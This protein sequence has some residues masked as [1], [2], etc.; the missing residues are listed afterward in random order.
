MKITLTML[1]S[2]MIILFVINNF[3]ISFKTPYSYCLKIKVRRMKSH[4]RLII[5]LI[6]GLIFIGIGYY[7]AIKPNT[8][9]GSL[10]I[11]FLRFCQRLLV[12]ICSFVSLGSIV[13]EMLQKLDYYYY[14]PNHFSFIAGLKS[15]V[16][17]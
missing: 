2:L 5:F 3:K 11:I 16:K 13:L 4:V 12:P 1:L 9:I 7:L 10:G 17:I 15:R 8:A 6:L 14:K